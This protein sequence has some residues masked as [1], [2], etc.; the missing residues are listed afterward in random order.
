VTD[1]FNRSFALVANSTYDLKI[2]PAIS[3]F[4][5]WSVTITCDNG[6]KTQTTHF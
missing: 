1:N 3:Q 6:T 2:V 5:D 4:R